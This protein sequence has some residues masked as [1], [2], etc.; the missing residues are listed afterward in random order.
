MGNGCVSRGDAEYY[1]PDHFYKVRRK[2][3]FRGKGYN[4]QTTDPGTI[5][6]YIFVLILMY[7]YRKWMGWSRWSN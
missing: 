3:E 1:D 7:S 4:G 2:I 6:Y 5:K